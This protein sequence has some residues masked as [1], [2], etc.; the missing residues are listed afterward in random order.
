MPHKNTKETIENMVRDFGSV[1]P[2]SKSEIRSRLHSLI[3][4]TRTKTLEE[5]EAVL[6]RQEK[7]VDENLRFGDTDYHS[8]SVRY[9]RNEYRTEA[10]SAIEGLKR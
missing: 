8:N 3:E 6:P 9:G 2:K 4:D 5:V 1:V 10:L 7:F